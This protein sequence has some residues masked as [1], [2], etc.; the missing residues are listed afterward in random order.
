MFGDSFPDSDYLERTPDFVI[1]IK[2]PDDTKKMLHAKMEEYL[3]AGTKLAW[4]VFP[5]EKSVMVFQPAK[6]S[7]VV[8]DGGSLDGY[9]VLP[10]LVISLNDIFPS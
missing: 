8:T 10:G 4:L 5:D 2:S 7:H 6:D 9:D 1:E 3:M